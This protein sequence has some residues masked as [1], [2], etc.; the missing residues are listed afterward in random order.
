MAF[1][2]RCGRGGLEVAP[3]SLSVG[4]CSGEGRLPSGSPL[5]DEQ[6]RVVRSLHREYAAWQR[7]VAEQLRTAGV[8]SARSTATSSNHC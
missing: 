5:F 8:E 6:E 3:T 2:V 7:V 4:A 1:D